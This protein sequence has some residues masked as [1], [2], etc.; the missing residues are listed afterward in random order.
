MAPR[1]ESRRV[2]LK[3]ASVMARVY[4]ALSANV[5]SLQKGMRSVE[6]ADMMKA[7]TNPAARPVAV[8]PPFVPGGTLRQG[9]VMRRGLLLARI[10]SSEEKVSAAT[11]A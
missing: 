8:M 11:A 3:P 10:P 6:V 7:P 9:A 5:Q 2:P 4:V 1:R